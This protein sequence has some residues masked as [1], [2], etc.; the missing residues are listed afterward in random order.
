MYAVIFLLATSSVLGAWSAK[1]G[2]PLAPMALLGI[3]LITALALSSLRL[4]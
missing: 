3:C 2:K 4:L 1:T